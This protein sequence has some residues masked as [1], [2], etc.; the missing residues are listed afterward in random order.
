MGSFICASVWRM[1]ELAELS[2]KK[3][4]SKDD[5][6]YKVRLSISRGRSMCD[7]CKHELAAKDLVPLL[8][9]LWLRGKCRYCHK[10]I[11]WLEPAS[12]LITA[13]LFTASYV[14]WPF[15]LSGQGLF[16]FV[17]WLVL[18]CGFV[19]LAIYDLRWFTLPDKLVLPLTI[20]AVIQLLVDVFV[21]HGGWVL[22]ASSAVGGV[23]ISGIFYVLFQISKGQWIG[24]GD[25]K[26]AFMLGLLAGSPLGAILVIFLASVFGTL[27]ALP[28]MAT[29]RAG[30]SSQLPFGPFLLLA[31][32]IVV[33][34][35][36]RLELLYE[37][38]F[39]LS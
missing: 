31:T 27:V 23:V 35:G 36:G 18:L 32:V 9:W 24:G 39:S 26:L 21:F 12:E 37:T 6:T 7:N 13:F 33:I 11:G 19:A 14:F 30:R 5:K 28:L 38:I 29:G 20:L 17:I 25:V 1:H 10:S 34:F 4:P 22:L 15:A 3:K 8:S 16:D 2:D